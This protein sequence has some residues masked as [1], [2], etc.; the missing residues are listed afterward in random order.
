M[1]A[2]TDICC[3]VL[4]Y[5]RAI[6]ILAIIFF[7]C[8]VPL[9]DYIQSPSGVCVACTLTNICVASLLQ[10]GGDLLMLIKVFQQQFRQ[11]ESLMLKAMEHRKR[12]HLPLF[13]ILNVA[14]VLVA[15]VYFLRIYIAVNYQR[16]C[17][18]EYYDR[19]YGT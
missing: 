2:F 19:H 17:T 12:S 6:C 7:S 13:P 8:T 11:E 9:F 3:K 4:F 1:G 15:V 16:V 10:P 5:G 14:N 18:L